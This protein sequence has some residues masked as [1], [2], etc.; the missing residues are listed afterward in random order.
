MSEYVKIRGK[1]ARQRMNDIMPKEAIEI[2]RHYTDLG[3]G[4]IIEGEDTSKI[5]QALALARKTLAHGTPY[6]PSGDL[7]SREALK[8]VIND[9]F[10]SGEYD[11]ASVLKAIDN[12]QTVEMPENAV[13]CVLTMF[14]NCSYNKTG[15]SDCEIKYKIRKALE[16]RLQGECEKCKFNHSEIC[17]TCSRKYSDNYADMKG[18]AE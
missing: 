6:N 5:K 14:G 4:I 13:N 12:A 18:G 10:R 1:K 17:D 9:L 15:C 16:E 7:I 8:E 3:Y 11:C 2:L